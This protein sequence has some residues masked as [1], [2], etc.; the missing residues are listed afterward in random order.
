MPV[1][2]LFY[3]FKGHVLINGPSL[4]CDPKQSIL[5]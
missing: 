1:T 4:P 5:N 2:L 3:L